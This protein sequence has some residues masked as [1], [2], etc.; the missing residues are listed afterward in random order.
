MTT[1]RAVLLIYSN[2]QGID[3]IR[4]MRSSAVLSA[5]FEVRLVQFHLIDEG[6]D[7]L[8]PDALEDVT[9]VW[10]QLGSDFPMHRKRMHSLRPAD[11]RTITFPSLNMLALWPFTGIDHRLDK[12]P[13]YPAGRYPW[14]DYV[15]A[16]L[17]PRGELVSDD[18]LFQRYM[19]ASTARLPDLDRRLAMDVARWRERDATCDVKAADHLLE[20]FRTDQLFYSFARPTPHAIRNVFDQLLARTIE[21]ADLLAEARADL[22]RLLRFYVGYDMEEC[23]VHPLIAKHFKLEWYDADALYRHHANAFTYRDY[24]IRYMR[25]DPYIRGG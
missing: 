25:Y 11:A 14:P 9:I 3:L 16:E 7:R 1:E 21:D 12:E 2:C 8:T 13:L 24:I 18:A 19:A 15:A 6:S 22:A 5:H 17:D 10:E 20:S 4:L 23:P